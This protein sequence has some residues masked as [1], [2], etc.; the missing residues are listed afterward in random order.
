FDLS[1]PGESNGQILGVR[2]RIGVADITARVDF[3]DGVFR[4]ASAPVRA[5][6]TL[7]SG[8]VLAFADQFGLGP[9]A[10]VPDDGAITVSLTADGTLSNSLETDLSLEGGGDRL[11]FFGNAVVNDLDLL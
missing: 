4:L 5:E 1:G 9:V 7:Q 6:V 8:Q 2:G 10:L 11:R 3:S